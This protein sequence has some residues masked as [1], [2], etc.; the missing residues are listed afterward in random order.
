[1]NVALLNFEYV[2]NKFSS[3]IFR[4]ELSTSALLE[5]TRHQ[6]NVDFAVKSTRYCTKGDVGSLKIEL[7]RD[8]KVNELLN[9]HLEDIKTLIKQ[10]PELK[11][12]DLKLLLPQ[13]FIYEMQVQFTVESF[14]HFLKL[15]TH[16]SAHYHIQE[17]AFAMFSI[18]P[19]EFR[20]L[21]LDSVHDLTTSQN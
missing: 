16:S 14:N 6:N 7:S 9:S 11:N 21:F 8:E 15:R 20:H 13:A 12:D 10:N 4:V 5:L 3:I 19:V 17:L 18:T 2:D 1:M